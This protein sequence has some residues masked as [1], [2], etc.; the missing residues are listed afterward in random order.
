MA[1]IKFECPHCG[2]HIVADEEYAG[3]N[4]ECPTC[5]QSLTVPSVETI[6]TEVCQQRCAEDVSQSMDTAPYRILNGEVYRSQKEFDTAIKKLH[7]GKCEVIKVEYDK[8]NY[9]LFILKRTGR[10]E[11]CYFTN[12]QQHLL[13]YCIPPKYIAT[14]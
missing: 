5:S 1:E 8:F 2:Q 11:I 4:C 6:N 10:Y 12:E 13:H 9:I 7:N 14:I 3:I